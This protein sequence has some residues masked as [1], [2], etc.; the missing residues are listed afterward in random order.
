M[1]YD[2]SKNPSMRA[3]DIERKIMA[4]FVKARVFR[5]KRGRYFRASELQDLFDRK[6]FDPSIDSREVREIKELLDQLTKCPHYR[7]HAFNL[8]DGKHDPPD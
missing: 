6:V 8:R 4:L 5:H 3:N 1:I 2:F 7:V